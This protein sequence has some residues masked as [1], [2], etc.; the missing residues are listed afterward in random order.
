M[1]THRTLA[2][3]ALLPLAASTLVGCSQSSPTEP[4]LALDSS[5]ASAS[6]AATLSGDDSTSFTSGDDATSLTAEQRGRGR[7]RGG[8]GRGND[9]GN[10]KGDDNGGRRGGRGG[11]DDRNGGGGGGGNG[12]APRAGQEFE[13][14]VRGVSGQTIALAGGTRVVV[15]AAT[16]WSVRGDLTSLAAVAGSAASGA[17]TRVEGRG[18]RQADG[19]ILARTIKAEVDN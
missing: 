5:F 11:R 15:S 16:Q 14:A 17:P 19:S 6:D 7:G 8:T 10:D 13:G 4:S 18:D 3:F 9:D 12:G 1:N 2:L